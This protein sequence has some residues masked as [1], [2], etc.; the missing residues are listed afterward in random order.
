MIAPADFGCCG[1]CRHFTRWYPNDAGSRMGWCGAHRCAPRREDDT[2][3]DYER[4]EED[5]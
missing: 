3:P 1:T 2:C 5:R 4:R